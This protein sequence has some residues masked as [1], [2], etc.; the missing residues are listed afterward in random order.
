MKGKSC[1]QPSGL[2]IDS[3]ALAAARA[4]AAQYQEENTRLLDLLSQGEE[5]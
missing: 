1:R 2:M 4:D 5:P 3:G